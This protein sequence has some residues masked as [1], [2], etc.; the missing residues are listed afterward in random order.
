LQLGVG[1]DIVPQVKLG[2]IP[3]SSTCVRSLLVQ[4]DMEGAAAFMGHPFCL[5]GQVGHGKKLGSRLGF[6][7]LNLRLPE[8]SVVPPF[9]V[10]IAQVWA[11]GRVYPTAAN[12]GVRPTLDDGGDVTAEGTLLDF[13]GNL[14]GKTVRMEF[15]RFLRP[16]RKFDGLEGLRAQVFRDIQA[17]RDF[18]TR[19][20]DAGKIDTNSC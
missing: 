17:T 1:Y 14:Y 7:T 18:F 10:Y 16:E 20:E 2:G 3:V 6:P 15:L 5:T 13:Q 8:G 12:L 19:T 9:G 11:D 4:G